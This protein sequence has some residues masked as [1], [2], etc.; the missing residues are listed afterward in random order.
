M[1]VLSLF[2]FLNWVLGFMRTQFNLAL[3]HRLQPAEP[4]DPAT[5]TSASG[6]SD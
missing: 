5:T 4:G 3:I 1:R 6:S 2:V